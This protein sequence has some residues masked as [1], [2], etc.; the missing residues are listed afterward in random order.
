MFAAVG[1]ALMMSA[2]KMAGISRMVEKP[3][4]KPPESVR[5]FVR[6]CRRLCQ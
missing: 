5:Y 3:A 6:H 1:H 2:V 4:K